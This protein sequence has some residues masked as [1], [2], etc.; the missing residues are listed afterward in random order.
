MPSERLAMRRV[1]DVIK[2]KSAGMASGVL[3]RGSGPNPDVQGLRSAKGYAEP[4][5]HLTRMRKVVAFFIRVDQP[6]WRTKWPTT[7]IPA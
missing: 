3:R 2:L 5:G 4:T 1:R 6:C 7:S